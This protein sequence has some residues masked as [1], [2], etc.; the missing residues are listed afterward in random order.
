MS[1]APIVHPEAWPG[2]PGL[3]PPAAFR[4]RRYLPIASYF[5]IALNVAVFAL[6]LGAGGPANSYVVLD[7]GASYEPFFRQGQYWRLVMPMFLHLG[8]LHL[9]MNMFVLFI[10]GP[11]LEEMYGYGRFLALYVGAGICGSFAS[12]MISHNVAAGAS[13]AIMGIAGAILVAGYVHRAALPRR[14]ARVFSRGRMPVMLLI[15]VV[16]ELVVDRSIPQID[17]W[18]HIG[19]LVGGALLALFIAPPRLV[20]A[21][22]GWPGATVGST[23]LDGLSRPL[24]DVE[25]RPSQVIAVIPVALVALSMA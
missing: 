13:G 8:W 22:G 12:M 15:F 2:T 16:M 25:R 10:L 24:G 1:D 21:V 7:F 14:L 6:M 17:H 20:P 23:A 18:G 9:G 11:V 4:A 3:S 5:L 19:G